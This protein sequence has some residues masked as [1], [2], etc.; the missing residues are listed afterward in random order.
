MG[1]VVGIT[2]TDVDN[3]PKG[4][5]L[6]DTGRGAVSGFGVRCQRSAKTFILKTVVARKARWITIGR[7][8]SPW[9]VDT[10]RAK[11]KEL[12][13][14][15]AAGLDPIAE[16][17]QEPELT[18]SALCDCYLEAAKAGRVLT[19]FR[20]PKKASTLAIDV[21]RIERH[22]KP[23]IGKMPASRVSRADILR[24]ID[25][26]SAGKTATSVKTGRRGR[27]VVR[28]G[29]GTASRVA[30]LLS[31]IF[32]WAS[33]RGYVASNPVQGTERYR[34][35]SRDR[36]LSDDEL[37]RLGSVLRAGRDAE[38]RAFNQNAVT[39]VLLLA[40]TGC[41]LGEIA[42]LR[43]GEIDLGGSCLRLG[44]TKTGKSV[45]PI[46]SWVVEKL[47]S[48]PVEGGTDWVFPARSG[49]GHYQGTKRE[50]V[51]IFA[52]ANITNATCHT[53]RHSFATIASSL[54]YSDVTIGG[55][56]GHKGRT[57]TSRYVH[58]VDASLVAAA[59][60]VSARIVSAMGMDGA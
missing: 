35:E 8:G 36:F 58:R 7:F 5:V 18:V 57:V 48:L 17:K 6:W 55:L 40:V 59:E 25:D 32:T 39:V 45:R 10:A 12:L 16:T 20:R 60:A 26:I 1:D 33:R 2:K 3:L 27:A 46:G 44:D 54:E 29:S 4:S 43:R 52:A 24:M 51:K 23:L 21:G 11:A 15:I 31:G 28:G 53:L 22:I 50:V 38:G 34:G 37:S 42:G 14:Q 30:D 41:R 47:R 56:L 49:D 9:T 13:G 19:R